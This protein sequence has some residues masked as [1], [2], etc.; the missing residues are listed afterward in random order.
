LFAITVLVNL[1][2]LNS[3]PLAGT[4]GH[5]AITAQQMVREGNWILPKLFDRYYLAKP[6]MQ[7]WLIAL[8]HGIFGGWNGVVWRMPGIVAAALLN[9]MLC[10]FA[11]RW[12]GRTAAWVAGWAGFGLIALWGQVPSADVDSVDTFF[13]MLAALPMLELLFGQSKRLV[14]WVMLGGVGMGAMLLTKG[15]AG[16]L[17]IG[18]VLAWGGVA[19]ARRHTLETL[20]PADRIGRR[21]G[22]MVGA[23]L[24]GA[25]IFGV[26]LAIAAW[27][28][29]RS[30]LPADY[31]GVHEGLKRIMPDAQ[32]LL[33]S[34]AVPPELFLYTLPVSLSLI[35]LPVVG[36]PETVGV[37][38]SDLAAVDRRRIANALAGATLFS[39]LLALVT[40]TENPRW[41]YT[42][43]PLLCPLAGAVVA[44]G[45]R[46]PAKRRRGV[47]IFFAASIL[48]YA[49][50]AAVFS[51]L[52]HREFAAEH[53]AAEL[54]W[55]ITAVAAISGI[56]ACIDLSAHR[57][58]RA[59]MLAALTMVLATMPFTIFNRFDRAR[60][61]GRDDGLELAGIIGP[62]GVIGSG[63]MTVSEPEMFYY[64][65]ATVRHFASRRDASGH[66]IYGPATSPGFTHGWVIAYPDELKNW[67][68]QGTIT[69]LHQLK[70]GKDDTADVGWFQAKR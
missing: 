39:W 28:M 53:R 70:T 52:F 40:A 21:W 66:M 16:L 65:G 31:E 47:G 59:G 15:P 46:L 32:R 63:R 2:L 43:V 4:E 18:G 62:G 67:R 37:G 27:Q 49:G 1:P 5:R 24:I 3:T 26:Y 23:L 19:T 38:G 14:G 10:L 41:V 60:R 69:D 57:L 29:H 68:Q 44:D 34:L 7:Y 20:M 12:F 54:C 64:A 58:A 22:A 56:G 36:A 50:A 17:P 48:L 33:Q 25:A 45:L 11:G 13:S 9:A 42:T 55:V 30:S 35:L 6:P 51:L 8:S 61:S